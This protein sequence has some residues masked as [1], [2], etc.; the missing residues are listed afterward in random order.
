[1]SYPTQTA[2]SDQKLVELSDVI[3][4]TKDGIAPSSYIYF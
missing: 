2:E 4:C 3:S 1:M